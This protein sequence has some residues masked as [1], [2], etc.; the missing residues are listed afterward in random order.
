[1]TT[2]VSP[3][4]ILEIARGFMPAK[5]LMVATRLGLFDLLVD[6]PMT[7]AEIAA[8]LGLHARAIPDFTDALVALRVLD[9]DGED[10]KS[11]V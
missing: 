2:D 3:A 6:G 7:G 5:V 1:M 4:A 8:R 9:R 10:R 11:V